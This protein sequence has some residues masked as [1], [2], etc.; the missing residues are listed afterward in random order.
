MRNPNY[1]E[2]GLPYLD[3]V[4]FVFLPDASTQVAALKSGSVDFIMELNPYRPSR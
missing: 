1:W 2:A 4:K 3:A